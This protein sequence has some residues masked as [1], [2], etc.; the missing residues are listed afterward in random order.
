M[1][2]STLLYLVE[3][4]MWSDPLSSHLCEQK[5]G[6]DFSVIMPS[7]NGDGGGATTETAWLCATALDVDGDEREAGRSNQLPPVLP[8]RSVFFP[9]AY[10]GRRE[11][12]QLDRDLTRYTLERRR[13]AAHR[14]LLVARCSGGSNN[15][16]HARAH[17]KTKKPEGAIYALENLRLAML[18]RDPA[19]RDRVKKLV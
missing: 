11:E 7:S 4:K 15:S 8:S 17:I 6:R 14:E 9:R 10:K 12:S 18:M 5:R 13:K 16:S 2:R 3:V 19:L 1:G